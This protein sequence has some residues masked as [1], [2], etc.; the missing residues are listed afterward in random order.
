MTPVL[1]TI[2]LSLLAVLGD[3]YL[4]LAGN[5]SSPYLTRQFALGL[6]LY[7]VS[8]FGVVYVFRHMKMGT[9]GAIYCVSL[10]VF[11]TVLGVVFFKETMTRYELVGL[12]LAVVSVVML[13]RF[14]HS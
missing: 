10:V 6:V 12:G 14:V 13:G 3:Y 9:V 4:K 11:L 8:A 1:V 2:V 7:A 5:Q